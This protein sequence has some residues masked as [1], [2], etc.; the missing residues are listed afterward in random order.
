[1]IEQKMETTSY[2][3]IPVVTKCS[4]HDFSWR[5][6][7]EKLEKVKF[8]KCIYPHSSFLFSGWPVF[9][10]TS[11]AP[12]APSKPLPFFVNEQKIHLFHFK[13]ENVPLFLVPV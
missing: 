11:A 1:M 9:L 6:A 8:V 12:A 3:S 13:G 4:F 10:A 7:N 2:H 5:R